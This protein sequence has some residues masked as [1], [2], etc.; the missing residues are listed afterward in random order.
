MAVTVPSSFVIGPRFAIPV[1]E[2]SA[3]SPFAT[4]LRRAVRSLVAQRGGLMLL[5]AWGSGADVRIECV[6]QGGAA[7][8]VLSTPDED[9]A[10]AVRAH[11][12]RIVRESVRRREAGSGGSVDTLLAHARIS[13]VGP[14][15]RPLVPAA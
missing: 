10:V 1:E 12:A 2:A 15:A 13:C 4:Q 6:L 11:V 9:A 8:L 5:R 7:S 3:R 14:A